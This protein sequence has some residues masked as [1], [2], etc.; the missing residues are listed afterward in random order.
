[1]IFS[2]VARS[3]RT[4]EAP[5]PSSISRPK[6]ISFW[7]ESAGTVPSPQATP[8]PAP[9][10]PLPLPPPWPVPQPMESSGGVSPPPSFP[11]PPFAPPLPLPL[12][13]L[14]PPLPLPLF[15]AVGGRRTGAPSGETVWIVDDRIAG[16]GR[17]T[18]SP[19]APPSQR[20]HRSCAT[21][22]VAASRTGTRPAMAIGRNMTGL[23]P[24]AVNEVLNPGDRFS[25]SSRTARGRCGEASFPP[26]RVPGRRG[27]Q[28]G[29]GSAASG[30]NGRGARSRA[31]RPSGARGREPGPAAS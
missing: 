20:T 23:S 14:P 11:P 27:R 30:R 28:A 8:F 9:L 31:R 10:P 6:S 25:R 19:P 29:H 22:T 7:I 21:A 26:R 13:R 24:I 16:A 3:S 17:K 5:L 2:P 18:G 1:M 4:L 15:W 12:P